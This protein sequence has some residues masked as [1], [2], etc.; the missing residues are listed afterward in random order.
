MAPMVMAP[1]AVMVPPRPEVEVKPW[2]VV[3]AIPV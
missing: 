3:P 1:M 2:A